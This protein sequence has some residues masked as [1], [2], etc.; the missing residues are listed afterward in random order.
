MD[1]ERLALK[2]KPLMPERV[3][4]WLRVLDTSDPKLRELIEKQIVWEAQRRLGDYRGKLLL[5]L[6]PESKS[7][8]TFNL[9]TV[10]YEEDKHPFGISRNELMQHLAIFGRSGSGKT[11]VTFHLLE[12]LSDRQIPFLFLD[13]KRT[14]RHLIP[15]LGKNVKVF[16]P[17]RALSPFKFN[18]FVAPPGVEIGAYINHLL[19]V[20]AEAFTLGEGAKYLLQ[21]ALHTYYK[22]NG[23]SPT[24][25]DVIQAIENAPDNTRSKGWKISLL[26]ALESLS[27]SNLGFDGGVDQEETVE[28]LFKS[29]TII[30]LESLSQSS[31]KFLIPLLCLWL[32]HS[33]LASVN[34]EHLEL[35]VIIEEAHHVLYRQEQRSK[36]SVMNMLIRQCREL[37]IGIIIVDQH[38][39]L[40]SSAALG[41]TYTT[42]CLNQK[43]PTDI[44]KAAGLSLVDDADK[45]FFSMLNTGEA[46]VKM[47]DRWKSPFLV[48]FPLVPVKKGSVSD[49]MLSEYLRGKDSL[50]VLGPI[51]CTLD[52]D[53]YHFLLE[54]VTNHRDDG[55]KARYNRLGWGANKGNRIKNELLKKGWLE[56]ELVGLGNTRRTLL[57]L[58]RDARNIV[59]DN[60]TKESIA[61]EHWKRFYAQ[62]FRERGYKVTLEAERVG[63]RV[64]VLAVKDGKTIGI[65]IETGKSDIVSNVRNCLR[66]KFH[67]VIVVATNQKALMTSLKSIAKAGLYI[68]PRVVLVLQDDRAT[69][70]NYTKG[71]ALGNESSGYE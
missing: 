67:H 33:K 68:P 4:H 58:S 6:P 39:H 27:I 12:Q 11:N 43:D 20:L 32:F 48:R 37:G 15:R 36:E 3:A 14:A 16:T 2:L 62:L 64:D 57:R 28:N 60:A 51:D 7:K 70:R 34:R 59:G 49:A 65:E 29:S 38:P 50:R 24:I 40:I 47:Q 8:G 21:K 55:V 46:I 23:K 1:I 30:E 42:I 56:E 17:G 53:E 44:N 71:S 31:K 45:K 19:D 63:G 5:S 18:P 52:R 26:R 66:S 54:D 25:G 9:G 10:V 22:E 69:I 41:N 35:V 61:H 13:W